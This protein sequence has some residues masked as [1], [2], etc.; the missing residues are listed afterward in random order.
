[1]QAV[2]REQPV[3]GLAQMELWI[4]A[5]ASLKDRRRVVRS[6]VDRL[7]ARFNCAVMELAVPGGWQRARV[8]VACVAGSEA[9]ARELLTAVRRTVEQNPDAELT[10]FEV[11]IFP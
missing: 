4:A 1:M 6:V 7:R 11:S 5:S 2:G 9:G 3:V 10:A 8:A